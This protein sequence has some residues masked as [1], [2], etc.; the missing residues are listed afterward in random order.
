M[1]SSRRPS[2]PRQ[3]GFTLLEV[4]VAFV[5]AAMALGV[6]FN[7]ALSG[8]A[9]VRNAG[10]YE[11]ALALAQSR[12]AL[13]GRFVMR[14]GVSEGEDGPFRWRVQTTRVAEASGQPGL[15]NWARQAGQMRPILYRV[16]TTVGWRSEGRS[17]EV[18]LDTQRLGFGL[19]QGTGR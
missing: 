5:I 19:P 10:L 14:E 2:M 16:T 9:T 15:V 1:A 3:R 6:L 7:T 17:R 13:Q 12:L 11:T 8:A 4:L 18:R